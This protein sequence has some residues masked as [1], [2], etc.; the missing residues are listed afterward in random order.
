MYAALFQW[1][2]KSKEGIKDIWD[3]SLRGGTLENC[4]ITQLKCYVVTLRPFN[5]YAR[6]RSTHYP[7]GSKYVN[8]MEWGELVEIG[9]A[10][11]LTTSNRKGFVVL[12]GY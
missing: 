2:Y 1:S 7:P 8:P 10:P 9:I 12:E 11:V 6:L 3:N 5:A 4:A